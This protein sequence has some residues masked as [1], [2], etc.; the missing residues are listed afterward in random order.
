MG[1]PNDRYA[2]APK[3][4]TGKIVLIVCLVIGIPCLALLGV[5]TY[6]GMK[7]MREAFPMAGCAVSME[8]L[9][10]AAQGYAAEH[11]GKLPPAQTWQEDLKPY[12]KKAISGK[13]EDLGPIKVV[14][15]DS[16]VWVCA[17]TDAYKTG[18]AYNADVAGK[19]ASE[20]ANPGS[21]VLFFETEKAGSNVAAKYKPLPKE[22]SPKLMGKNRGWI[23]VHMEGDVEG[24]DNNSGTTFDV[25]KNKGWKI[26]TK[27]GTDSK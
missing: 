24:F 3:S 11:D 21:T 13:K 14:D 27:V 6:F 7:V 5:C 22:S 15:P 16:A 9:R 19:V 12:L 8:F 23:L 26:E 17:E 25:G 2:A 20:V 4:N 18:I 10:E 1:M